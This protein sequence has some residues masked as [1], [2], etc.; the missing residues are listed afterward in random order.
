[1][2]SDPATPH[3]DPGRALREQFVVLPGSR[4]LRAVV[5][6]EGDGPLS[7]FEAG[8]SAPGATWVHGRR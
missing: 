6:G 8:M 1:M 7:V 2:P 3:L 5:A 4:R